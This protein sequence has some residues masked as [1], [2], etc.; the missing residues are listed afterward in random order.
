M[1]KKQIEALRKQLDE[2]DTNP[3]VLRR[4]PMPVFTRES[5]NS[6]QV[7]GN[8]IPKKGGTAEVESPNQDIQGR[9]KA[10]LAYGRSFIA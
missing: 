10:A 8:K 9:A 1:I 4:D 5:Q 6:S 7:H 3:S 2:T